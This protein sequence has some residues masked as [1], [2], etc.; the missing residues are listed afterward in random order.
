MILFAPRTVLAAGEFI[1]TWQTTE[2]GEE[3]QIPTDGGGYDYDVD[4]G[5]GSAHAVAVQGTCSTVS[6]QTN[7][8]HTYVGTGSYTIMAKRG[9]SLERSDTASVSIQ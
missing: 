6:V 4:W 3:I 1:T 5:D 7:L 2:P 8:T 9:N